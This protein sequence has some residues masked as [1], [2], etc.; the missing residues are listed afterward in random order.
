MGDIHLI[1]HCTFI[2]ARMKLVT[3]AGMFFGLNMVSAQSDFFDPVDLTES[4]HVENIEYWSLISWY[5]G[6]SMVLTVAV[7]SESENLEVRSNFAT[8]FIRNLMNRKYE[9]ANHFL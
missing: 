3:L 6:R 7:I 4:C 2:G 5:I 1:S 9:R 8:T